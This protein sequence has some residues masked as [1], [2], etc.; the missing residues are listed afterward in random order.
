[1][2]LTNSEITYSSIFNLYEKHNNT[3]WRRY[4]QLHENY[5]NAASSCGDLEQ[6]IDTDCK[7]LDCYEKLHKLSR[8]G[9]L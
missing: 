6:R 4:M 1:M 3:P 2:K 9:Q 5:I 7:D 8:M